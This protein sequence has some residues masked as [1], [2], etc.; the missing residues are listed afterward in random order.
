MAE[1]FQRCYDFVTMDAVTEMK[2]LRNDSITSFTDICL[3]QNN[4]EDESNK[5]FGLNKRRKSRQ[6]LEV[7]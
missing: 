1:M 4:Y 3:V 6:D 2:Y 7:L 5:K